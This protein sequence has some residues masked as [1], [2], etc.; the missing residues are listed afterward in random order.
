[1]S[2]APKRTHDYHAEAK[3]IEGVL[4]SP[5]ERTLEPQAHSVLPKEGG[6]LHTNALP[7][8]VERV[9]SFD[10]AYSHVAGNISGK[11]QAKAGKERY[12]GDTD[13][14]IEAGFEDHASFVIPAIE[15]VI[16]RAVDDYE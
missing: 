3:I 4:H 5:L 10:S 12:N 11:S 16:R 14:L 7:F 9:L 8:R 2:T 1:M 15:R 13:A 6:Y